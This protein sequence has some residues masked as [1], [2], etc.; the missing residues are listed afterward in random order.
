MWRR[1][2][3]RR[4]AFPLKKK[5]IA[6]TPDEDAFLIIMHR[7]IKHAASGSTPIKAP[8][9]AAILNTFNHFFAFK[10]RTSAYGTLIQT[11]KPR[12]EKSFSAK[13]NR[14]S[15]ELQRIRTEIQNL[16][17]SVIG[18]EIYMPTVTENEIQRYRESKADENPVSIEVASG[19]SGYAIM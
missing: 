5:N 3:F 15:T 18:G 6:Y 4:N 11:R 12:D 10:T 9:P 8:A 17:Q 16:L 7:K 1:Q 2:Y 14:P 19:Q 13:L